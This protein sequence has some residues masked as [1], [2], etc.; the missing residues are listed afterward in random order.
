MS[1]TSPDNTGQVKTGSGGGRKTRKGTKKKSSSRKKFDASSK[2]SK[3]SVKKRRSGSS[4]SSGSI[5]KKTIEADK[6][7]RKGPFICYVSMFWVFF[8]THPPTL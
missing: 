1:K 2:V 7:L 4:V 8:L 3:S 5:S 6:G